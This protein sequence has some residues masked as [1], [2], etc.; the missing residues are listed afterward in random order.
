MNA[1]KTE[2]ANIACSLLASIAVKNS[3]QTQIHR[4]RRTHKSTIPI[5]A[6]TARRRVQ[7]LQQFQIRK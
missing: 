4:L 6:K 5:P 2:R 7:E 1:S 3:D